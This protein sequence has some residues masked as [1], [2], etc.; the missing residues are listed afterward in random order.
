MLRRKELA[1]I[2]KHLKEEEEKSQLPP[3]V[4]ADKAVFDRLY[5]NFLKKVED[6]EIL[7]EY[8]E[9]QR[10]HERRLNV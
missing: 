8:E 3:P 10:E 1:E 2:N 4:R 5:N 9:T 7:A 6:R